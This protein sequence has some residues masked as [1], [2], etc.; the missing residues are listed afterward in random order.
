MGVTLAKI[1]TGFEANGFVKLNALM[2]M[3]A[4][5]GMHFYQ[6]ASSG[7]TKASILK[8]QFERRIPSASAGP[9][10]KHT[11]QLGGPCTAIGS[12]AELLPE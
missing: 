2:Q 4:G 3:S 6:L 12:K 11:I 9:C 7:Q 10:E 5:M 8:I 1:P